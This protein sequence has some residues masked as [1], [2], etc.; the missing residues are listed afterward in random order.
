MRKTP[1]FSGFFALVAIVVFA[2]SHIRIFAYSPRMLAPALLLR[3][4][5]DTWEE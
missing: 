5:S 4:G 1:D 3:E 2:Y